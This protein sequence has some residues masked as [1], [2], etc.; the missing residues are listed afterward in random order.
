MSK[1]LIIAMIE[2][3]RDGLART[4]KAV[5]DDKLNWKPLD[6][7]RS[8]LD[9]LGEAAQTPQMI[10]QMLHSN[11]ESMPSREEFQKLKQERADWDRDKC[12]QELQSNSDALIEAIGNAPE[13]LLA[14]P[15]H[16]PMGGGMTLAMGV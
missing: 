5:P 11:G 4:A 8:V 15:I 12:L 3:G 13:E 10:T 6:N 2:M 7:G 16:S 14:K 1:E 9:V